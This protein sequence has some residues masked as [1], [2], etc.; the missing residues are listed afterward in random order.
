MFALFLLLLE[1]PPARRVKACALCNSTLRVDDWQMIVTRLMMVRVPYYSTQH[2]LAWYREARRAQ[3][4]QKPEDR[5]QESKNSI[6]C[7]SRICGCERFVSDEPG[8]GDV[9]LMYGSLAMLES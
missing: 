2:L 1:E 3:P 4:R 7:S 6:S 5:E 8:L 9:D